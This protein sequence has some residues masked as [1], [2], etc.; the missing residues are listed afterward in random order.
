MT[1]TTGLKLLLTK[2]GLKQQYVALSLGISP[3]Y[4]CKIL[5][6]QRKLP[7]RLIKKTS[8]ILNVSE[9]LIKRKG[10]L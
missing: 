10:L 6:G 3:S 2:R 7:R 5:Q 8:E 9:S 4:L 1:N